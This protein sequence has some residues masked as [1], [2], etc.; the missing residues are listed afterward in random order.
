MFY[1]VSSP[2]IASSIK[3][4]PP[5]RPLANKRLKLHSSSVLQ[6]IAEWMY[7]NR[8]KLNMDKTEYITFGTRRQLEKVSFSSINVCD[9]TI[10][11]SPT[12]RNLCV[13][14][15][16]E[17]KM[18]THVSQVVKTSYM[19]LRKIRSIRKFLSVDS[20][21]VLVNCFILSRLDYC[22][23]M[24]YG[25]SDDTLDRLQKVQNAA[26]RLIFNLRKHEHITETLKISTGSLSDS[27]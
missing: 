10:K 13:H 15:D 5:H 20:L 11:S 12:V 26:A 18:K 6:K 17:L 3:H 7:A 24:L 19:H 9:T 4:S 27:E 1:T 21:K 2:T 25:I 16:R 22:N 14:L 23:S 8:L